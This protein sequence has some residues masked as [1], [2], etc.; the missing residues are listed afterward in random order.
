MTIAAERLPGPGPERCA[1]LDIADYIERHPS[2]K[3]DLMPAL[4]ALL[5]NPYRMFSRTS[6]IV[7][8]TSSIM[9]L[10]NALENVLV[11]EHVRH[12]SLLVPGGHVEGGSTLESAM[13]EAAEEVSVRNISPLLG[14][15]LHID[16]HA[17]VP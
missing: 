12:G 8:V 7:H 3:A 14:R 1:L 17:I 13:R 6:E 9:I 2:E 10:D 5:V 11:I 15:P 16:L 4:D